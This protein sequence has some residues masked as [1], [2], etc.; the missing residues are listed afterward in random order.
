MAD[1]FIHPVNVTWGDCDPA[2]I[3]YT[4]RLP[5]F[6]LD[7]IN[8]WWEAHLGGDGWFQMEIDRNVG[9]PFVS[10]AMEFRSPVTPRHTLMCDTFP[11]R[12]GDKSISFAVNGS[13]DGKLCFEGRFTCVFTIADQFRSQPVPPDLRAIVEPHIRAK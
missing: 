6:A 4:A 1:P 3:A 8:A 5:Y 13:Q 7:A 11:T 2:R 12:L 10:L 9:T